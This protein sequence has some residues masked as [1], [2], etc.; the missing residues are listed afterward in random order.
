MDLFQL[1]GSIRVVALQRPG[2]LAGPGRERTGGNLD[3]PDVSRL[4]TLRSAGN[5]ELDLIAFGKALE[6]VGLD[7][8]EMDEH[9]LATLLGDKAIPLRIV[10]PLH[11]TLS[12]VSVSSCVLPPPWRGCPP[13]LGGKQKRRWTRVHAASFSSGVVTRAPSEPQ[14]RQV[15]MTRRPGQAVFSRAV[16]SRA[17]FSRRRA[18]TGLARDDHVGEDSR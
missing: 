13:G 14:L 5:L 12:H 10:K 6:A 7:G 15:Y 1:S 11:L 2:P 18:S 9:V 8:A 16:F 17:V 4:K 3:L